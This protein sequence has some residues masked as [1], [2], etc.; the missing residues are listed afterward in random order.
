M[1]KEKF[2]PNPNLSQELYNQYFKKVETA[3]ANR[4]DKKLYD[5]FYPGAFQ[6]KKDF[7]SHYND[8]I[9]FTKVLYEYVTVKLQMRNAS[10]H[11]ETIS[12][13]KILLDAIKAHIKDF[14]TNTIIAHENAHANVA[15]SEKDV[16]HLGYNAMFYKDGDKNFMTVA[17]QT[18]LD[19]DLFADNISLEQIESAERI[20][21]APETY[22]VVS[23][24][25]ELAGDTAMLKYLE[26]K[27]NEIKNKK[28]L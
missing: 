6:Q 16:E 11:V 3:L 14:D 10:I 15:D 5:K 21:K 28:D 12:E 17:S 2:R 26:E 4:I 19:F 1:M 25:E 24:E 22:G 8:P 9:T 27:K 20:I 7:W 18:G 13:L 23:S